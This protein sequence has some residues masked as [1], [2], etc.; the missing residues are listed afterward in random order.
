MLEADFSSKN[1]RIIQLGKARE[2]RLI[3]SLSKRNF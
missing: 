2:N 3:V 1:A